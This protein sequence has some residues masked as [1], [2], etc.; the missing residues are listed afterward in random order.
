MQ[1]LGCCRVF[2]LKKNGVDQDINSS[3]ES[4]IDLKTKTKSRYFSRLYEG[5]IPDHIVR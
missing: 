2:V 3:S 1:D 4:D 5:A